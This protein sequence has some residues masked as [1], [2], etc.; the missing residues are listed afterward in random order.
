MEQ[1]LIRIW[2]RSYA[3]AAAH[4][5]E[6]LQRRWMGRGRVIKAKYPDPALRRQIYRT[7]LAPRSAL[8]LVA[9]VD[10]IRAKMGEG[11]NYAALNADERLTIVG[12]ILEL[13]SQ[14]PTFHVDPGLGTQQDFRE[15]REV[16]RWWLAKETLARQPGPKRV[17]DWY[18]FAAQNFIYRGAWGL[19]SILSLLLDRAEHGQPIAALEIDDWPRSGLPWSAFWL[20]EL[21]VWGTLEPVTAYLLARGDALN[22][23]QADHDAAAYYDQLPGGID[24]NQK[25]NPRRIRDWLN[26]RDA[27]DQTPRPAVQLAFDVNLSRDA[28]AYISRNLHVMHY[29]HD[30]G[31]NWIDPAG[32]LVATSPR[33]RNWPPDPD[34]IH[35]QLN[36]DRS[37]INGSPYLQHQ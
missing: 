36:V 18:Y 31:L 13:L 29:E 15:W 27:G 16:L 6:R 10:T 32:Y 1:E 22:R 35:F 21:L 14:V 34:R 26:T 25:L 12:D 3:F 37:R 28:N 11:A 23:A 8:T 30:G 33:P 7:S 2:Q 17:T 24:D 20:K 5:Q 4:E 19:G 9:A